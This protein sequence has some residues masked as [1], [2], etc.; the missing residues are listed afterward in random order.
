MGK[1][2]FRLSFYS[3]ITVED[4]PAKKGETYWKLR[5][6]R[7]QTRHENERIAEYLGNWR[8]Y[9]QVPIQ[10]CHIPSTHVFSKSFIS[11]FRILHRRPVL[12]LTSWIASTHFL[13]TLWP[14]EK[15]RQ[16]TLR[17]PRIEQPRLGCSIFHRAQRL[18]SSFL[19]NRWWSDGISFNEIFRSLGWFISLS[20]VCL[21]QCFSFLF[22]NFR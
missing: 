11:L 7:C 2:V 9:I 19:C 16:R 1:R 20:I 13:F 21:I 12:L 14:R 17:V 10:T 22:L 4:N 15:E 8:L 6:N 5:A 18:S 3:F